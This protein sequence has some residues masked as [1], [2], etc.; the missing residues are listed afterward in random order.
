M[1][2]NA[3]LENIEVDKKNVGAAAG[4]N[5]K[6]QVYSGKPNPLNVAYEKLCDDINARITKA[7]ARLV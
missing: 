4:S 1:T 6:R 5:E 2:T 3:V 7:K